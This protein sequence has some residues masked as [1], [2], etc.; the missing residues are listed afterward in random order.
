MQKAQ[1]LI[2]ETRSLTRSVKRGSRSEFAA[3]LNAMSAWVA[4]VAAA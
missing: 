2:C 4:F 1:P 3:L